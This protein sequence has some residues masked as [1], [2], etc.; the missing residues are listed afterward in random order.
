MVVL[1]GSLLMA[2]GEI[3]KKYDVKSGKIDYSISVSGGFLG[4]T[5]KTVGKKRVIFDAYGV[6]S[7]TELNKIEK[8]SIN[9]KSTVS[10]THTMQYMNNALLYSVNF[11]SK[12][13]TRMQNPGM[14]LGSL[15]GGG[16]NMQQTG[17]AM[18]QK[19]GGKKVGTDKV[20]GYSCTVWELMGSRQCL[21][22]GIPLKI[23]TNIMGIKNLEVATKIKF[24]ISTDGSFKLPN[25]P[26]YSQ[27]GERLNINTNQLDDMDHRDN[28]RVTKQSA[29]SAAA[30]QA[31]VGAMKKAGFDT[32]DPNAK[33][34]KSQ[35]QSVQDSMMNAMMPQMKKEAMKQEAIM[36]FGRK[37][38]IKANTLKEA[39]DCNRAIE[40]RFGQNMDRNDDFQV[41]NDKEKKKVLSDIDRGIRMMEC[42]KKASSV[43]DAQNCMPK[44]M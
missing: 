19:M 29:D 1:G 16:K 26:I 24:D 35:K 40:K 43:Q 10:K 41:W 21:Y 38:I 25:L 5:I 4:A 12:K 36:L 42:Q 13:I 22:K 8:K 9:G 44:G 15:F 20:L 3:M 31:M 33:M 17:K 30:M 7:L 6:K 14:G 2:S 32:S 11:K 27:N 37:C 34:T 39:N 23:E 28:K 18:M